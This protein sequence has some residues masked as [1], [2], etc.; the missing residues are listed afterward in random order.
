MGLINREY[1]VNKIC[2]MYNMDGAQKRLVRKI[3]RGYD[4]VRSD[5]F[6][7]GDRLKEPFGIMY[8]KERNTNNVF[9]GEPRKTVVLK[10]ELNYNFREKMIESVINRGKDSDK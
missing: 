9:S 4:E 3:L 6:S 10:T 5:I 8:I 1:V 7:N 2:E